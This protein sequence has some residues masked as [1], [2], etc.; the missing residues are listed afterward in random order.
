MGLLRR[1]NTFDLQNSKGIFSIYRCWYS[2]ND[3]FLLGSSS[4]E[5][6]FTRGG[7][8]NISTNLEIT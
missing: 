2:P 8:N 4:D 7:N 3:N 5:Y 6:I 1:S